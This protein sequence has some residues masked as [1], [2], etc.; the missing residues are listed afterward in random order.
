MVVPWLFFSGCFWQKGECQCHKHQTT[1]SKLHTHTH[2]HTHVRTHTHTHTHAR[3]HIH[4]HITHLGRQWSSHEG[5]PLVS[6]IQHP[7][8]T[9][10]EHITK[11]KKGALQ[12]FWKLK[13]ENTSVHV[14]NAL[15]DSHN[16]CSCCFFWAICF[17]RS[18]QLGSISRLAHWN[19]WEHPRF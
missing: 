15:C 5:D 4:T 13:F 9:K 19:L 14:T 12:D 10:Y 8:Q 6:P 3:T 11:L 18:R 7:V 17:P 2:T 1:C 16:I